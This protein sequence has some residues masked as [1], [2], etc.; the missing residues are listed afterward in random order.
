MWQHAYINA[1]RFLM[2]VRA[3]GK[4]LK[5]LVDDL[6]RR[7][8]SNGSTMSKPNRN[9]YNP[10]QKLHHS[11][12]F[13]GYEVYTKR[14]PLIYQYLSGI[15]F[16]IDSALQDYSCVFVLRIDLKLPSDISVPQERLIERFIASLRSKVRSASKKSTDQG[17]RVHPTNIRYVWC[18]EFSS[19]DQ[20][21]YHVAL[22]MNKQSYWKVGRYDISGRSLYNMIVGAW[23]SAL[24]LKDMERY[25]YLVNFS[26]NGQYHMRRDSPVSVE[27]VFYRLSY[28]CKLDTKKFD[29]PGHSFGCSRQ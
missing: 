28:L 1:Y 10:N 27:E 22:L 9:P 11:S 7:Q 19:T 12:F 17:K 20:P 29:R 3:Q 14:G 4:K 26:E 18:K 6:R 25:K 16:C 24:G 13:N 2:P 5:T 21:H 8:T 23:M 15:E